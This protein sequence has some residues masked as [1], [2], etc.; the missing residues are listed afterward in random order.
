MINIHKVYDYEER[1]FDSLGN[2][3]SVKFFSYKL[4]INS[5][6]RLK[7]YSYL[8][9]HRCLGFFIEN[10]FDDI[11]TVLELNQIKKS[12]LVLESFFDLLV[13]DEDLK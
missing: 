12:K 13:I 9:S 4:Y 11:I 2:I 1:V 8:L 5:K 10:D 3:F 6:L 7:R